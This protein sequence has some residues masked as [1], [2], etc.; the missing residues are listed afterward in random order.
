MKKKVIRWKIVNPNQKPRIIENLYKQPIYDMYEIELEYNTGEKEVT[1][2]FCEHDTIEDLNEADIR[3][4]NEFFGGR[5]KRL[6]EEQGRNDYIFLGRVM[7][8]DDGR[9]AFD[10]EYIMPN[11]Q[12]S[13]QRYF[14]EK[15]YP[16]LKQ[17]LE[18]ERSSSNNQQQ[19]QNSQANNATVGKHYAISDVHGMLGSYMEAIR[20]LNDKDKLIILGDA[21]D[22]GK[23]GIDILQDIMQ[24]Q[25]EHGKKPQ[26]TYML[27]NHDFAFIEFIEVMKRCNLTIDELNYIVE[28]RDLKIAL[29]SIGIDIKMYEGRN[30]KVPSNLLARRSKYQIEQEDITRK[31]KDMQDKKG[32][33]EKEIEN[34]GIW[35][36]NN[37]GFNTANGFLQ[38]DEG[39]QKEL[40]NF[41]INSLVVSTERVKGQKF[42]FTHA[43]PPNIL[44][45][46][47]EEDLM[48]NVTFE[49][50]RKKYGFEQTRRFL[51]DRKGT[52]KNKFKDWKKFGF[53]TVCGHEPK[54]GE[55]VEDANNGFICIDAGCG[56]NHKLALYCLEDRKT[57]MIEAKEEDKRTTQDFDDLR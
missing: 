24:R 6:K 12:V 32:I 57:E 23:Y 26:V 28:A 50:M 2:V 25:G 39:K 43:A 33:S 54:A 17:V 7:I 18:Q 21:I 20:K 29:G 15:A 27:G 38:L 14:D 56:S 3:L 42:L 41:L 37:K 5:V 53:I 49:Q 8:D 48:I 44:D 55:I 40:Y 9:F 47:N 36:V 45:C 4:K 10:R 16:A 1:K 31:L 30:E 46:G 13:A 22:R 34:L 11:T 51:E 19:V 52:A 35:L